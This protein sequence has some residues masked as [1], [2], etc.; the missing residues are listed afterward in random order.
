MIVQKELFERY[1]AITAKVKTRIVKQLADEGKV[2]RSYNRE[3]RNRVEYE[4]KD[5]PVLIE[6]FEA[7]LKGEPP[8]PDPQTNP[9]AKESPE[10]EP[11]PAEKEEPPKEEVKEKKTPLPGAAPLR[12]V[13]ARQGPERPKKPAPVTPAKEHKAGEGEG[14]IVPVWA[15]ALLATVGLGLLA[16]VIFRVSKR[17][18][19]GGAAMQ[20]PPAE[21]PVTQDMLDKRIAKFLQGG[22][23]LL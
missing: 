23:D 1:P 22:D 12:K 11:T 8:Q 13:F 21:P 5:E 20:S 7:Y 15:W 3:E 14:P 17:R 2:T 19:G 4:D 6:A 9:P 18:K 16:V 10:P